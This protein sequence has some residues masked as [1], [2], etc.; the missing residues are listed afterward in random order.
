[1]IGIESYPTKTRIRSD[2]ERARD[3]AALLASGEALATLPEL[4]ALLGFS[5]A[6]I[7]GVLNHGDASPVRYIR[8][9]GESRARYA[10]ADVCAVVESRRADLEERRKR[11]EAQQ[12]AERGAAEARKAE[13]AVAHAAHVAAKGKGRGRPAT[14]PK[15]DP[16]SEP[17]SRRQVREPEVIVMR[18]KLA[19]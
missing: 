13:R 12:A 8:A 17:P 11:A 19:R 7:R 16:L 6:G 5:A 9:N 2:D 10:V 4:S 18:R 1:V 14:A 15:K 3:E